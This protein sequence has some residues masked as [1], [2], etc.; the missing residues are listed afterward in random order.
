MKTLLTLI[1]LHLTLPL[2][3][4]DEKAPL[5][6]PSAKGPWEKI[7]PAKIGW[8]PAKLKEALD[9]VGKNNPQA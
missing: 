5:Y 3:A 2:F 4:A 7:D 8:N 6:F 9:Y 1:T